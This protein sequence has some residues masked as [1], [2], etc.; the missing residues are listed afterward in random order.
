MRVPEASGGGLRTAIRLELPSRNYLSRVF[1][2]RSGAR[3]KSTKGALVHMDNQDVTE[4]YPQC[5]REVSRTLPGRASAHGRPE[6]D[7][8]RMRRSQNPLTAYRSCQRSVAHSSSERGGYGRL[9][10]VAM[11]TVGCALI[12]LK[13]LCVWQRKRCRGQRSP[14]HCPARG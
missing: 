1:G 2:R 14:R 9:A 3:T 10:G 7:A 6:V 8:K 13:S 12:I 4:S 11:C 5:H